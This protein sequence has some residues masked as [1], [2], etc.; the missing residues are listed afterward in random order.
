MGGGGR[1]EGLNTEF[2]I[3]FGFCMLPCYTKQHL[4]SSGTLQDV[5]PRISEA[6]LEVSRHRISEFLS[7]HIAYDL[8]P[9]SGKV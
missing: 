6:D 5:I 2:V 4:L 3:Y 8:L 7:T 9:E 1:W